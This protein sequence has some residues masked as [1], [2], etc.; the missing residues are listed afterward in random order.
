MFVAFLLAS[1]MCKERK[2][3]LLAVKKTSVL[4]HSA[5]VFS[6]ATQDIRRQQGDER[7]TAN[8]VV[9]KVRQSSNIQKKLSVTEENRRLKLDLQKAREE[10]GW[11]DD[12][13]RDTTQP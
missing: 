7:T 13:R 9:Q 2:A 1:I 12:E 6:R 8:I 4:A 10:T 5:Q 3:S 11:R